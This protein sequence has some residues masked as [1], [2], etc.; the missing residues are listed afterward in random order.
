[1]RVTGRSLPAEEF[2]VHTA[3]GK[4][5][6][7][8]LR[9]L[10]DGHLVA[11]HVRGGLAPAE[12]HALLERFW[13]SPGLTERGGGVRG[14]Y[15]GA[16]HYG[17]PLD[18]Y[19]D[20]VESTRAAVDGVL[21]AE[22]P[23]G[24][25][26]DAVHTA[27]A[28]HGVDVRLAEHGARRAGRMRT[29][30]WVTQG[31]NLLDPHEDASQLRSPDLAEFEVRRAYDGGLTAANVYLNLPPDGGYLRVWNI[32]P[33]EESRRHFGVEHTGYYY[34]ESALAGIPSLDVRPESGDIL[35]LN[36][37]LIHAVVGYGGDA[38]LGAERV[39]MNFLIGF[40][41]AGTAVYWA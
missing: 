21:G 25:V 33:D 19:L 26:M 37:H 32:R 17:T 13:A 23:V 16:Y 14:H 35:F 9:A 11:L 28:P 31:T 41:D 8:P 22:D 1:M 4:I 39:S 12:R 40:V 3:D 36:G 5:P 38:D 29:V 30:S 18:R 10:L 20:D 6:P 27:L 2:T 24:L 34:P 7:E 15:V